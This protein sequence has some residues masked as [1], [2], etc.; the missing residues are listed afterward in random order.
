MVTL[1]SSSDHTRQATSHHRDIAAVSHWQHRSHRWQRT[2]RAIADS[3]THSSCTTV[4]CPWRLCVCFTSHTTYTQAHAPNDVAH[5]LQSNTDDV[6]DITAVVAATVVGVS[7]VVVDDCAVVAEPLVAAAV[8]VCVV[9][10]S[11][12][13]AALPPA[14]AHQIGV[15]TGSLRHRVAQKPFCAMHAARD[16]TQLAAQQLH[17]L[18]VPGRPNEIAHASHNDSV[19]A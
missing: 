9:V 6:V 8:E 17:H 13:A 7:V 14:P 4:H 11:V 18:L 16:C 10:E 5:E 12:V 2:Q 3:S 1:L 19:G 15:L